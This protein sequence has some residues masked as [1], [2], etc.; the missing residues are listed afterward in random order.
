MHQR[1]LDPQILAGIANLELTA[2]TVVDG[3]I[4][5]LHRSPDFG[6]SQEF[7]E[8]RQY[9]PGDDLRYVDWNVYARSGRLY[10]KRYHGE[11]NTRLT[12]LLDRSNSME[13]ASQGIRKID[14]AR[15]LAASMAY[16]AHHQ[17]DAV[18][19]ITFDDDIRDFIPP[20]SRQ[21]QWMK[22]LHAIDRAEP[23]HRTDFAKPFLQFQEVLRSRGIVLVISD[24]YADPVAVARTVAPL[25]HRGND[26]ILFHVLDPMEVAP[27]FN[28]PKILIDLETG[29]ELE[30]SPEYA[31]GP[32]RRKIDSHLAAMKSEAEAAG[33]TYLLAETNKP[34]DRAL[35]E[36]LS[37]R[38]G[39]L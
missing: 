26:V 12:V 3:F 10:L 37:I 5:G 30:V 14:Y 18:G 6:F 11:T 28:E 35:R 13:F 20:S 8:Y 21:G 9:V 24:F 31:Q 34:L 2:R 1:F 33:L 38:Q 15:Y 19:L 29:H 27:V 7:A 4:A 36:Y 32:Y 25:R 23:G 17:R 16:L 39:R 22:V